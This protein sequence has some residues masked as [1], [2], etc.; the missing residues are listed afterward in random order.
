MA[1]LSG[2]SFLDMTHKFMPYR[3]L[4]CDLLAA[5]SVSRRPSRSVLRPGNAGVRE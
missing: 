5:V 2:D 1:M 3:F 4:K